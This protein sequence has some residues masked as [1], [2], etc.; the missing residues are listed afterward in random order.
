MKT[1]NRRLLAI[2]VAAALSAPGAVFAT[3]GYFAHGYGTKNKGLVGGGVAL[4]QDSMI[5]ATNP[6]GMAYVGKRLDV[7]LAV[8]SPSP[9]KYS[10]GAPSGGQIPDGTFCAPNCPVTIGGPG[11]NQSLESENDFFL[12][13]HFGFNY[14]LNTDMS[15][16]VSVYGNGGMNTEWEGG[17]TQHPDQTGTLVTTP[18]TYGAGTA[19]VNLEQLFVNIPFAMKFAGGK[20]SWGIAPIFAYQRFEAKGTAT[21][22]GISLHPDKLSNQGTDTSAGWGGKIGVQGDI[23]PVTLAGSYQSKMSM[24][25]FDKYKG[26]FA[27]EG[28]F[29]IPSTW[30]LGLAWKTTKSSALTFDVQRINYTDV[31]SISNSMEPLVNGSCTPQGAAGNPLAVGAGCLGGSNGGGFGWQDMTIYKIGYQFATSPA[32]AWRVGFSTGDQPIQGDDV[33]FNIL[34]PGVVE[35]HFTFGFTW[36][37]G[38]SSEV[39]FAAMYA[40][41][42][43]VSGTNK[44]RPDQNIEIEMTQFELEA[45]WGYRF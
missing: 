11:G 30:T 16:G 5:A 31:K 32:W 3:N 39:N 42:N 10:A 2:T 12:I 9:R 13:P 23:G 28:G 24:D 6:A 43:S 17:Q 33:V 38:K 20:A 29:D 26:L 7:G 27:E 8:F 35:Q 22:G 1:F 14:M 19:G 18:G 25:K 36:D 34:A 4:P 37:S 41:N 21:F 44:F 45:S 40:P 15:I